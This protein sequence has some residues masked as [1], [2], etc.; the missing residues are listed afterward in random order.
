MEMKDN[1]CELTNR[2]RAAADEEA[3]SDLPF[4][5]AV[6]E[7]KTLRRERAMLLD[8]LRSIRDAD[9]LCRRLRIP[10]MPTSSRMKLDQV[11]ELFREIVADM[12]GK[13]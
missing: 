1:E 3:R 6:C 9:D 5:G 13:P 4:F 7:I 8:A 2:L 12:E 11:L 10:H